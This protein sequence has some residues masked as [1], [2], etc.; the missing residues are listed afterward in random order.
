MSKVCGS[1]EAA[2]DLRKSLRMNL[3]KIRNEHKDIQKE[4]SV[5]QQ[6]CHDDSFETVQYFSK[7]IYNQLL[8]IL[9]EII[10]ADRRLKE[11]SIF[12]QSIDATLGKNSNQSLVMREKTFKA[13]EKRTSQV[14]HKQGE[15]KYIFDSPDTLAKCLD[16]QQ[17]KTGLKG[18]C[19]LC[20]VENVLHIS[21]RNVTEENVY[22]QALTNNLCTEIG[23]TV[24]QGRKE[25]LAMYGIASHFREQTIDN[26]ALA[27]NEG[28]IV[29]LSVNATKLYHMGGLQRRLHAVVVTSITVNTKREVTGVTICDSNAHYMGRNGAYTY[30]VEELRAALTK[31][32]MNV[33]DVIR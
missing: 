24:P 8:E 19:G 9:P 25:L 2:D 31:R 13:A 32:P 27:I 18:S 33:T 1:S 16:I 28:R 20:A 14:W 3:L 26:I 7:L 15:D 5:L 12:V 6:S 4:L 11:Y 22:Q 21:G 23:G 17:G 30:S 10:T 29:I